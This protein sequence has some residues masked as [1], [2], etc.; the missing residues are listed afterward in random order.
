MRTVDEQ[1]LIEDFSAQYEHLQ[2]PVAREIERNV[3]GCDYGGTSWTTRAEADWIC[4]LLQLNSD[5]RLLEVGAGCGWPGLYMARKTGCELMLVDLPLEGLRIAARRVIDDGLEGRCRL[6]VADAVALPFGNQ[7][8]DAIS[9]SDVLCCL[10][11]KL[12]ALQDC[13]R[14]MRA[15]GIMVFTVISIAPG[16]P[17]KDHNHAIEFGPPYVDSAS[18]YSAMLSRS[19]WAIGDAVDLTAEYASTSNRYLRQLE[20]HR[21]EL[22]DLLGGEEF[23]AQLTRMRSKVAAIDQGLF[24]R[25]LYLTKRTHPD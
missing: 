23:R 25:E 11:K 3:C 15:G 16:L 12:N 8:F 7:E 20:S 2:N 24:R 4:D 17:T 14:V 5:R 22:K 10:D 9:H 1:T 21:S 18:D 19:G 6:V 13:H